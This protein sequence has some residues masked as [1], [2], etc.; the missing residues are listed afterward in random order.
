MM[1]PWQVFLPSVVVIWESSKEID[2]VAFNQ[3]AAALGF[4][5]MQRPQADRASLHG[6]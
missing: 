6:G 5:A 1:H 2:L 3:A 4:H